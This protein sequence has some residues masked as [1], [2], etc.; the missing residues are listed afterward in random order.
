MKA[1]SEAKILEVLKHP[2]IIGFQEMY[3]SGG[4]GV[5]NIVIEYADGGDLSKLIHQKKEEGVY[6]KE[7]IILNY[8]T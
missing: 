2:N 7:D 1:L 5:L 6:L 4:R 8:F 3:T